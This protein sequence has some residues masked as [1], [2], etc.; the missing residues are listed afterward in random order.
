MRTFDPNRKAYIK[1]ISKQNHCEFCNTEVLLAQECISLRTE[2]WKVI[3]AIYP[4]LDGNVMII[5]KRHVSDTV[6]LTE[7]EWADFRHALDGAKR[8]LGEIFSAES[9]NIGLNL[10]EYSGRSIDHIHWQIIPRPKLRNTN[11]LEIFSELQ[12]ITV[13]PQE[14]RKT[15][16]G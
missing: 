15:I 2:H 5:P 3:V 11:S 7:S 1:R 14:L 16:D 8:R 6:E 13:S 4:Y 10:G 9:F 12:V